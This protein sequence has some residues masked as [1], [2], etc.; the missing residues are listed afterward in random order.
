MMRG[1]LHLAALT[2]DEIPSR[3]EIARVVEDA[4]RTLLNGIMGAPA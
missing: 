4:V 3:D 2:R 1:D